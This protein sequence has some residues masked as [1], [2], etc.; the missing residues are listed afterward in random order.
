M[1][2]HIYP[3]AYACVMFAVIYV[4]K[5]SDKQIGCTLVLFDVIILCEYIYLIEVPQRNP[6]GLGLVFCIH[7]N[8]QTTDAKNNLQ[9]STTKTTS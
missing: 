9:W 3:D 5:Q 4:W 7:K 6:N 8:P 1:L 2:S